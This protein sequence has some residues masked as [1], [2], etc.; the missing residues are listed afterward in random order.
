MKREDQQTIRNIVKNTTRPALALGPGIFVNSIFRVSTRVFGRGTDSFPQH[1][2][3]HK[4]KEA[5]ALRSLFIARRHTY[6]YARVSIYIHTHTRARISIY[7]GVEREKERTKMAEERDP[8]LPTTTTTAT[9]TRAANI[10][11]EKDAKESFRKKLRVSRAY[12]EKFTKK[13]NNNDDKE[14]NDDDAARANSS[15]SSAASSSSTSSSSSSS[16]YFHD[17]FAHGA[18]LTLVLFSAFFAFMCFGFVSRSHY[19]RARENALVKAMNGDFMLEERLMKSTND[20]VPLSA[21]LKEEEEEEAEKKRKSDDDDR[22]RVERKEKKKNSKRDAR[23][24][25]YS[26]GKSFARAI[27]TKEEMKPFEKW[28]AKD[29]E[30]E[31]DKLV[32]ALRADK[33]ALYRGWGENDDSSSSSSSS[34]KWKHSSATFA[35]L[36]EGGAADEQTRDSTVPN[37]KHK[38]S[39]CLDDMENW[40][41][42]LGA[43]AWMDALIQTKPEGKNS[44]GECFT[45]VV[46]DSG[47]ECAN[48]DVRVFQSGSVLWKGAYVGKENPPSSSQE[49]ASFGAK[50]MAKLGF[51]DNDILGPD[52]SQ[53]IMVDSSPSSENRTAQDPIEITEEAIYEDQ[54]AFWETKSNRRMLLDI[55]DK[56]SKKNTSSKK[57]QEQQEQQQQQQQQQA[58][59]WR[60]PP[61]QNPDQVYVYASL[62][63]PGA[64]GKDLMNEGLLSQVDYIAHGNE[65]ASSVWLPQM[66]STKGLMASYEAFMRSKQSRIPGIAWLG[67]NC[68]DNAP[69]M[70]VLKEVSNHFPVFS[71]GECRRNSNEPLGLPEHKV[72]GSGGIDFFTKTQLALSD[73]LFYYVGEDADCPGAIHAD[74][75]MALARGSIPVYFGTASVYEYLPCP[76]GDC[77][78][79]VKKFDSSAHLAK[80]LRKI[81]SSEK[82]YKKATEWRRRSP[83]KWPLGF[84]RGIAR[85]SQD[86]RKTLCDSVLKKGGDQ[87]GSGVTKE[88]VIKRTI[89]SV[90]WSNAAVAALTPASAATQNDISDASSSSSNAR[91]EGALRAEKAAESGDARASSVV[92]AKQTEVI[93]LGQKVSDMLGFESETDGFTDPTDFIDVEIKSKQEFEKERKEQEAEEEEEFEE[94][95]SAEDDDDDDDANR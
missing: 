56:K 94:F 65:K 52:V 47:P 29:G 6:R 62:E 8:L 48:A 32:E 3:R 73:Y 1:H 54:M 91:L 64:F 22:E 71:I 21:F 25:K 83:D 36:M 82:L 44:A 67:K 78:V 45:N 92:C 37:S 87:A 66:I 72:M 33:E 38:F 16:S 75:W 57:E 4:K 76:E 42:R 9:K 26:N 2:P 51:F 49:G 40:D 90:P 53:D 12:R 95:S 30:I 86:F 58:A 68:P 79:D 88:D 69:K 31:L 7:H 19:V 63:T 70:K 10:R 59:L 20:L 43:G 77:I 81:S 34:S 61:K 84:K 11:E 5:R 35:A 15:S 14:E 27:L 28:L 50:L 85:A 41:V 74:L 23:E 46:Y 60:L 13:K 39:L 24:T 17:V 18:V 80:E 55:G 89:T 93:A